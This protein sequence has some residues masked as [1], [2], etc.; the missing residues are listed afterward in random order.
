[1]K[2]RY[3]AVLISSVL[4]TIAFVLLV[5]PTWDTAQAGRP[6]WHFGRA[7]HEDEALLASV[8]PESAEYLVV[9]GH[10]GVTNLAVI[11]VALIVIWNGYVKRAGWTWFVMFV[12]VWAWYF[13]FS[14]FPN[15]RCLKEFDVYMWLLSWADID[16]W[17]YGPPDMVWIFLLMLVALILPVRSFLR[18]K[19][20]DRRDVSL[21]S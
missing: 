19:I 14:V 12:I 16:S 2:I 20:G 1:M 3:D 6:F 5:P 13:P 8:K 18:R 17:H 15:L 11:L 21:S 9:L 7:G 10:L 4:F